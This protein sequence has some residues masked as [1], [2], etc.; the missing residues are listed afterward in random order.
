MELVRDTDSCEGMVAYSG[1]QKFHGDH[2]P[3]WGNTKS[4]K[5]KDIM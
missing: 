5:L 1:V 4:E 2:V 3:V